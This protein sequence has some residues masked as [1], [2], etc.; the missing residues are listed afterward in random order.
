M[1]AVL[2]VDVGDGAYLHLR[3]YKNLQGEVTLS[4]V[5]EGKTELEEIAYFEKH[6]N[7]C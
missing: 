4:G 3:I 5:E 2:Q 7:L 6:V 1:N